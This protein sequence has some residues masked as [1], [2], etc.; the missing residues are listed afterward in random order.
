M[1]YSLDDFGVIALAEHEKSQWT[2]GVVICLQCRMASPVEVH[3]TLD[4]SE[5][6]CPK[7]Q[8]VE[9]IFVPS[10]YFQYMGNEKEN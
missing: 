2:Y 1:D 7:C 3:D 4:R 10:T 8:H 6:L 9:S 5:V